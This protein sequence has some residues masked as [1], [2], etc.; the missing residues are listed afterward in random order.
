MRCVRERPRQ[1]ITLKRLLPRN[2]APLAPA[3]CSSTQQR[4]AATHLG[5]LLSAGELA[6]ARVELLLQLGVRRLGGL[7]RGLRILCMCLYVLMWWLT[8]ERAAAAA[9]NSSKQQQ[10]AQRSAARRRSASLR[11]A[12]GRSCTRNRDQIFFNGSSTTSHLVGTAAAGG[13]EGHQGERE[14]RATCLHPSFSLRASCGS[15]RGC[16]LTTWGRSS[17]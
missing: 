2:G 10:S 14:Q 9:T 5:R 4:A 13:E 1:G 17:F 8:V 7:E 11:R 12:P 15:G 6:V 3:T 16:V